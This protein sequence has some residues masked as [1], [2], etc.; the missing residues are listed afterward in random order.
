[1]RMPWA[2]SKPSVTLDDWMTSG[3]WAAWEAP[4]NYVGGEAS[5]GQALG[6]LR[7]PPCADGYCRAVVIRF[8]REPENDYDVNAFRAVVEGMHIGY[9]RRHIA[10]QLAPALD[11]A[12][13]SAFDAPGLLRGGST[14]ARHVGCHVWLGRCLSP[15]GLVVELPT[16]DD[17]WEVPWPP[18]PWELA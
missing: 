6:S 2:R 3:T 13:F 9:L 8:V 17:E 18:N 10:A 14:S 1:M 5:Y 7:G 4:R 15:K 12:G 11:G 16:R